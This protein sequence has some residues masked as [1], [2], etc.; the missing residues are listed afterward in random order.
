MGYD[1]HITRKEEWSD[2][3]GPVITL[4]EWL[5]VIDADPDLR[6]DGFA[7]TTTP[8]GSTLRVEYPGLAVWT[9][10]PVHREPGNLAWI[11]FS[12]DELVV[13]NPDPPLLA[14]LVE[15]AA[16]L[17]ANVQG[18]EGERYDGTTPPASDV[19][20]PAEAS[21]PRKKRWFGRP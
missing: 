1:V 6:H 11:S 16:R 8:D 9:A 20:S 21:P 17:G 3:D 10:H 12:E 7:E 2:D 4:D 18:D 5:A 19:P 13:K 14:K 15:I